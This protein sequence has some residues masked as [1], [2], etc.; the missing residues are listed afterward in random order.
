MMDMSYV[1]S[2]LVGLLEGLREDLHEHGP[3]CFGLW[4]CGDVET[5]LHRT[6]R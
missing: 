1:L 5:Y 4:V 2:L 3:F 6:H